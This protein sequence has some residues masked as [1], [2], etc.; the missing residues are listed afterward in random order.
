MSVNDRYEYEIEVEP[1]VPPINLNSFFAKAVNVVRV[2][3][4]GKRHRVDLSPIGEIWGK[5]P[6]EARTR[7]D[8][9]MKTWIAEQG[10]K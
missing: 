8:E 7:A 3:Q 1:L 10:S 2:D 5:D 4:S 9:K 6:A